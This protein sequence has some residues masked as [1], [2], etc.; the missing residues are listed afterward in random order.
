MTHTVDDTLTEKVETHPP[1]ERNTLSEMMMMRK[2][3]DEVDDDQTEKK[4]AP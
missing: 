3:Y 2:R 1:M 4:A